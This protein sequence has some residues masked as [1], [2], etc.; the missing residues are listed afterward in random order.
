M[1][2][3]VAAHRQLLRVLVSTAVIALAGCAGMEGNNSTQVTLSGAQE[4]PPVT[5]AASGFGTITIGA[6]KSVTG[7]VTTSGIAGVAAHIH[8]GA[9][10]KNGP[11]IVPMN[12]TSDNSWSFA[13]GAKFTDAQFDAYKAG[14]TYVNVHSVANKGGEIRG[15]LKP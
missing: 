9:P 5:T 1:N 14:N 6:D 3:I 10:G 15:Q 13:P 11:V 4:V 8:E 2:A 12:K 7:S